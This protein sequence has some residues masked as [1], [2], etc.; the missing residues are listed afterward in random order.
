MTIFMQKRHKSPNTPFLPQFA[1]IFGST[2]FFGNFGEKMLITPP[3]VIPAINSKKPTSKT[4][5]NIFTESN[6][7]KQTRLRKNGDSAL[8]I[9]YTQVT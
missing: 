1:A 6:I 2:G 8:L 5:S 3:H 9:D 7:C 4:F